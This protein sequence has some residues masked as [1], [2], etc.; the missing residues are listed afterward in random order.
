MA[1][2]VE[3]IWIKRM[4][5][6][7]MDARTHV[8]VQANRGIVGN[9][10]QGGRRQVTLI[11]ADRWASHMEA[12][13]ADADPSVRRANVLLRGIDLTATRGSVLRVGAV[14]LHIAGETKPCYQMDE[15]VPGLQAVMRPHWG[16]GAF[17][18]VLDDGEITVGDR[19]EWEEG[20]QLPLGNL[21]R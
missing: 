15:A 1:G 17:A 13:G 6:G 10:N 11:D 8:R 14:R 3:R 19:A 4:K 2:T 12:L 20:V 7:P 16:G 5:G 18:I 21:R 9:A